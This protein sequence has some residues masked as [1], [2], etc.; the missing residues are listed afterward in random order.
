MK[1]KHIIIIIFL[2]G[3]ATGAYLMNKIFYTSNIQLPKAKTYL[4][5]PENTNL[6]SLTKILSPYL[7][8]KRTFQWASKIKRFSKP[9]AGRYL[10]KNGM[11]N[12]ELINMLRIGNRVEVNVT[13]NNKN[14]LDD[15]AGAVSRQI[16][17]DS[18]SLLKAMNDN[19]FI[20]K[21][22]FTKDNILLMY[23]PN[24]YRMYYNT[25]AEQFR[26]KMLKEYQKFWTDERI[27]QAKKQGLTPIEAGILASIIQKESTKASE[28]PRIAGVYLNRL[29]KGM[30]LQ[31]DPTVV[32]A[33]RQKHGRDLVIKR[34]LNKHKEID[35]PYNTYKYA[36]LPPGPVCM[37]DIRSIKA[38]LQPEK[39]NYLYF[40]ADFNKP[41]YHI[42]SK[43]LS[44]HNRHARN[45]HTHLNRN[46]I[47]H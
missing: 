32:Y 34:V 44:E 39:H 26:N 5:V 2:L 35:S 17:P 15:L 4:D 7:K 46:R 36:G 45:Y 27:A 25:S 20:K 47:Y 38:V 21:N 9:K 24:T 40:V 6:D 13:F 23:I 3:M 41:G 10:L 28:L 30:L 12:N 14:Y 1:K 43:S 19:E 29:K 11:S 33:Y 16:A 31:A 8:S 37:P 42:F 18:L 22:A